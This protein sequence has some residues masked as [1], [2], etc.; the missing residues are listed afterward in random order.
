M[1]AVQIAV[2]WSYTWSHD[3][4]TTLAVITWD[5]GKG[6]ER[7]T[8]FWQMVKGW[9]WFYSPSPNCGP[10]EFLTYEEN[11]CWLATSCV[12]HLLHPPTCERALG[13]AGLK[14]PKVSPVGA[15]T[16]PVIHELLWLRM[17]LEEGLHD[18]DDKQSKTSQM[19]LGRGWSHRAKGIMGF[20]VFFLLRMRVGQ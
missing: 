12:N 4:I 10:N 6:L 15:L 2:M 11:S 18:S 14:E 3:M 19:E 20:V 13:G 9:N 8:V 1:L 7:D 17:A 16:Q 5:S